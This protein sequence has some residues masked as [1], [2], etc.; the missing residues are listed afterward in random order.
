[1]NDERRSADPLLAPDKT[2]AA[3]KAWLRRLVTGAAE[4]EAFDAGEVDAVMD[5]DSGRA[6]LLP[7]AHSS[8]Q[9]AGRVVLCTLD[10]LPGEVCVLDASGMVV[11]ANKAWRISG[12]A[13]A[14]AG[15]D[16]RAGENIFAACRDAPESE[17]AYADAVAAGLR[18]V[19]AGI[20][21]SVR[22]R[23]VCPSPGGNSAFTLSMTAVSAQG[24]VNALLTRE[25]HNGH[26]QPD[27]ARPRPAGVRR[28]IATAA[29]AVAENDLLAALSPKDYSRL[30]SGLE[31]VT[32]T[33]GE[34]LYE[35]GEPMRDVYFPNNC[36]VS[37]LTLV[38]G[39]R[40]LEVGLVGR[41]GMVGGR[42]ALGAKTSSVRALVQGTGTAMRMKSARFLREFHRSPV[43]QRLLLRFTDMLMVQISQT[44]ACNRFHIVEA[45][46][47]RWLLMTAE[48][49]RSARF[50][51]THGFLADMLGVRRE[52]VTVAA[53]ALQRRGFIR[54]RRGDITIL[55]QQ[56]LEA[57]CCSCYRHLQLMNLES[58]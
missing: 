20:R 37:L 13:H 33:Y 46:L 10:A 57:V 58:R 17:R 52:G 34:V 44:A 19:L 55:D 1:M 43:L 4:L 11:M 54:Y 5:R 50:H 8:L 51:L 30:A 22:S 49:M 39:H 2:E 56:G 15:L 28:R 7:V 48:R 40:A 16:V 24:P 26:E 27:P 23:Y 12:A 47:A 14:R 25:W 38:E 45:R 29:R 36:L 32:I 53:I 3:F 6:L 42:L 41:E 21:L 9:E 31:P 35:P 18:E